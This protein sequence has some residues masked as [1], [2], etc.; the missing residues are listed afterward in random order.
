MFRFLIPLIFILAQCQSPH[1]THFSQ[2]FMTIETHIS[3]G[4]PLTK[5]QNQEIQNIIYQTFQ[6][7]DSVY[8]KWNPD[9]EISQINR[10]GSNI[11]FI[12]STDLYQFL[13]R[14]GTFVKLTEGRFDPT[15]EPLQKLWKESIPSDAEIAALKPAIGWDKLQ[16]QNGTL[17]KKDER[18]QIDL[19]GI[20]KGLCVDLLIERLKKAGFHHLYVEWGGEI[21]TSENH[22]SGRPWHIGISHFDNPQIAMTQI[23]L[24]DQALATSGDYYQ[25]WK[26]QEATYCHIFNPLTLKPLEVK[27]GSVASASLLARDCVTADALAK[28]LM[29]FESPDEAEKWLIKVKEEYPEV[30]CWISYRESFNCLSNTAYP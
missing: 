27:K 22:P 28:V 6:E 20:A 11:P 8:N 15:I 24:N 14:I 23:D 10:L 4:D 21:R 7:I 12:L 5:T 2:T 19:G 30:K 18:T 29:F 3:I 1:P 25:N 17:I 26:L 9:S 13:I 16:F